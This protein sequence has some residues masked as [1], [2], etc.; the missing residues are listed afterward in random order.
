M[1]FVTIVVD[2][3]TC[4]VSCFVF[5]RG[6]LLHFCFRTFQS[7]KSIICAFFLFGAWLVP[8]PDWISA[9]TSSNKNL[10]GESDCILLSRRSDG[11]I[12]FP[13]PV[14]LGGIHCHT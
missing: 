8:Y 10:N 14:S 12:S 7:V 6:L 9:C 11:L 4:T 1:F 13:S 5:F 2:F 3:R